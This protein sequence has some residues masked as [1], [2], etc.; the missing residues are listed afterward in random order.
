MNTYLVVIGLSKYRDELIPPLLGVQTD[1]DRVREFFQLWGVHQDKIIFIADTQATRQRIL[2]SIRVTLV[3]KV[4]SSDTV[5]IYFAGHGKYIKENALND[6]YILL[7]Y[8]SVLS[9]LIGTG[10]TI[11]ELIHGAYRGNPKELYIFVDACEVGISGISDSLIK[12]VGTGDG[13]CFCV[14]TATRGNDAVETANGGI[15]TTALLKS[16]ASLRRGIA[17]HCSSLISCIEEEATNAGIDLPQSIHIG[18]E[19]AWLLNGLQ[20]AYECEINSKKY[21]KRSDGMIEIVNM[22]LQNSNTNSFNI[23]GMAKAGKTLIALQLEKNFSSFVYCSIELFPD[24][25]K[26]KS[27][28]SRASAAKLI[29][30]GKMPHFGFE[31][32]FDIL[33][34]YITMEKIQLYII[35]DHAERITPHEFDALVKE[36]TLSGYIKIISFSR[37]QL[38]TSCVNTINMPCPNLSHE[39]YEHFIKLY[40][41]HDLYN[42]YMK[43]Y[44]LFNSRP[45]DLIHCLN[46]D[47]KNID[48][49]KECIVYVCKTGGFVDDKLFAALFGIP[50]ASV[51]DLIDAGLI[52]IRED[53]F[54]P[55]ETLYEE[56][57]IEKNAVYFSC[58]AE[59]YWE[60]QIT[61][62]PTN[63]Y[64]C[65][66]MQKLIDRKGVTWLKKPEQ[67]LRILASANVKQC[68]W[69]GLESLMPYLV[70][71]K[72]SDVVLEAGEH[73]A[74]IARGTVFE[75]DQSIRKM[76]NPKETA[77]WDIICSEIDYWK[78][79]FTESISRALNVIERE[80]IFFDNKTNQC[81]CLNIAVAY[82]FL[83]KWDCAKIYLDGITDYTG[84]L[85]GWKN[86]IL[87]TILAIRGEDFKIG[88]KM[89]DISIE[90]LIKAKDFAGVGIAY[91]NIGECYVKN[92]QYSTAKRYLVIGKK[93]ALLTHDDATCLEIIRNELLASIYSKRLYDV[94]AERFED[95]IY[96]LLEVVHDKT[97]LMQVYN[98]LAISAAYNYQ[99]D[100]SKECCQKA[101]KITIGNQEYEIYTSL[102]RAVI[103]YIE[104]NS[105]LFEENLQKIY[106]LSVAGNNRFAVHQTIKTMHDISIIYN[107]DLPRTKTFI[108]MENIWKLK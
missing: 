3:E 41:S 23:Y 47:N 61:A 82:F 59:K 37:I 31:I 2:H 29:C 69:G 42:I 64:S 5:I 89:L 55:H 60:K 51:A 36:L 103:N 102:S 91:G 48:C 32:S 80:K 33:I 63:D 62:T 11:D 73:L 67:V 87:G 66:Q 100:R 22:L 79:N 8:D 9:D 78:G 71:Y 70:E 40:G 75:D 54:V 76:L 101:A 108:E 90:V 18:T 95:Q 88:T 16:I 105:E 50:L 24:I 52:L 45:L 83:G 4:C 27:D 20:V 7:C 57:K 94:E 107:L 68:N 17:P 96:D 30:S 43:R 14:V 58:E 12:D 93:Y 1:I 53:S 77:K 74:H 92:A 26:I 99:I 28:I 21:V 86:L 19:K 46:C 44:D 72:L 10:I 65:R 104:G 85:F 56:Y 106:L 39:E 6:K 34:N 13:R 81:A 38:Q 15:F 35:L 98:T 97:E 84:R 25:S 49:K